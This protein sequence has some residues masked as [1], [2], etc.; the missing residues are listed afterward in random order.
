MKDGYDRHDQV[1]I[2]DHLSLLLGTVVDNVEA[3]E[4][5]K[6]RLL[7]EEGLEAKVAT[8]LFNLVYLA[9]GNRGKTSL[10]LQTYAETFT[11]FFLGLQNSADP[12]GSV[13][14]K[15]LRHPYSPLHGG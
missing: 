1:R 4:F 14:G 5:G 6:R 12:D 11:R 3:D 9:F 10:L 8:L 13:L 2:N 7:C 15:Q